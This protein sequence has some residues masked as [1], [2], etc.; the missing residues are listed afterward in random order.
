MQLEADRRVDELVGYEVFGGQPFWNV[1][2][3]DLFIDGGDDV[4]DPVKLEVAECAVRTIGY[5]P[6]VGHGLHGVG[7]RI[8]GELPEAVK[9]DHCLKNCGIGCRRVF[10]EVNS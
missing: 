10:L 1:D 4:V 3:V 6:E 5:Q 9:V 2:R 8:V 7:D